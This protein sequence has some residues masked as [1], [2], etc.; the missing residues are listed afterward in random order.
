MKR[1]CLICGDEIIS[2]S[3]KKFYCSQECNRAMNRRLSNRRTY[4]R[5]LN[6]HADFNIFKHIVEASENTEEFYELY[7]KYF[8]GDDD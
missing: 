8:G 1:I 3:R 7:E 2:G 6:L 4:G 5:K